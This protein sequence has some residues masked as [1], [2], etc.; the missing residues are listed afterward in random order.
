M[1][2]GSGQATV[3]VVV[4]AS[5]VYEVIVDDVVAKYEVTVFSMYVVVLVV[6]IDVTVVVGVT[7]F[8]TVAPEVT[9]GSNIL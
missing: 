6:V 2:V 7:V 9:V 5:G 3:L 1:T 8:V 4:I